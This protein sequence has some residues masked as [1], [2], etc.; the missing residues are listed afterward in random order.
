MLTFTQAGNR[1]HEATL[2]IQAERELSYQEAFNYACDH[3]AEAYLVYYQKTKYLVTPKQKQQKK[4]EEQ[5]AARK[6][7]RA[8]DQINRLMNERVRNGLAKD[9]Q[10]AMEQVRRAEPGL[11]ET[12]TNRG[13]EAA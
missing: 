7:Q 10:E 8:A 12:Y 6:W 3:D 1:L 13:R 4:Q 2:K 11:W 9:A 5:K